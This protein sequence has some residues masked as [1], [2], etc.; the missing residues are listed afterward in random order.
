MAFQNPEAEQ[1]I[2]TAILNGHV[3]Y[4]D[5]MEL[6][7][8]SLPSHQKIFK[9]ML[10]LRD[11]NTPIDIVTI[12][13]EL[14]GTGLMQTVLEINEAYFK[15]D[16]FD[17]YKKIVK[18]NTFKRRLKKSILFIQE[19]LKKDDVTSMKSNVL[20][21]INDIP[22]PGNRQDDSI[23]TILLRTYEELEQAYNNKDDDS[24][25]TGIADLDAAMG[26]LHPDEVTI[27]AARPAVGKTALALQ[28]ILNFARKGN[29]VILF[30]REM[31]QTRNAKRLISN[32]GNVDGQRIRTGKLREEDWERVMQAC[33]ELSNMGI[34][35]NDQAGTVPEIRAICREKQQ[36]GGLDL[37]V[38][39]Y[40][41]LLRNN[42]RHDTREREVAEM[43]RAIKEMNLEMKIPVILLSQLSR[44]AA[45]KRPTLDTLR[46]SGAIEQ[47]A[48]NVILLHKPAEDELNTQAEKDMY[49]EITSNGNEYI[50]VI[51]AKQRDGRTGMFAMQY[52]PKYLQ[53]HS[54]YKGE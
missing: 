15:G 24:K 9:I 5:E 16:K 25:Q 46:E 17:T 6:E 28:I 21:F 12:G 47:D 18:E 40:L 3:G 11:K 1:M 30:S 45:N 53:F 27:L 22:L 19:E 13:T 49:E 2:L 7:D 29:K 8:F 42:N 33:G 51:I 26:G 43:S 20:Q 31:S 14:K 23:K 41:Q 50:E 44:S 35:I 37:I 39:D 34:Y 52:V 38:I 48:D 4:L 10:E 32:Q 36:K 54:I